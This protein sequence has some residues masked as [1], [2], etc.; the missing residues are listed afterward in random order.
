MPLPIL[1]LWP[2][3]VVQVSCGESHSAALTVDGQLFAWGRG[4]Y[5]QLGERGTAC[6]FRQM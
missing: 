5:G 1:P 4:K 6:S 2:L 3:G